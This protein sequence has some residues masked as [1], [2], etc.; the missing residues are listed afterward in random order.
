MKVGYFKM[1]PVAPVLR[2]ADDSLPVI[3]TN[4]LPLI[5]EKTR[6][7]VRQG[8]RVLA[9]PITG[10]LL[11][12]FLMTSLQLGMTFID[13]TK[14]TVSNPSSLSSPET[15]INL[16]ASVSFLSSIYNVVRDWLETLINWLV[17]VW[18]N[19]LQCVRLFLGLETPLVSAPTIIQPPI[20]ITA[21]ENFGLAVVPNNASTTREQLI[22]DNLQKMFA[23]QVELKFDPVGSTGVVTPNFRDDSQGGDYVFILT[24]IK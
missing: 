13:W 4:K 17:K 6:Q 12:L 2:K 8:L 16:P 24:P 11:A 18:T 7:P 1:P 9:L 23:D 21:G 19:L 22:R 10:L 3:S 15:N 14:V 5:K 20:S